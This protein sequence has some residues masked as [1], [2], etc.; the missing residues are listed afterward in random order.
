MP[1]HR[2]ALHN[3]TKLCRKIIG[4]ESGGLELHWSEKEPWIFMHVVLWRKIILN[5]FNDPHMPASLA[6]DVDTYFWV[7]E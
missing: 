5:D 3:A 4:L 2:C 6:C 7:H 1:T